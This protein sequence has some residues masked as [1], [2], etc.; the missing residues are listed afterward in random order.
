[1][2]REISETAGREGKR[3]EVLLGESP[4]HSRLWTASGPCPSRGQRQVWRWPGLKQ[5]SHYSLTGAVTDRSTEEAFLE[6]V[7]KW[8]RQDR[9][10]TGQQ[11]AESGATWGRTGTG[12]SLSPV[13]RPEPGF[14]NIGEWNDLPGL[15]QAEGWKSGTCLE[16]TPRDTVLLWLRFQQARFGVGGRG[17][18]LWATWVRISP[19]WEQQESLTAFLQEAGSS[20]WFWKHALA[21][22][23]RKVGRWWAGG[24]EIRWRRRGN[25]EGC[26]VPTLGCVLE[27]EKRTDPRNVDGQMGQARGRCCYQ[28]YFIWRKRAEFK[29]WTQVTWVIKIVLISPSDLVCCETWENGDCL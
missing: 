18:T 5:R 6:E 15:T 12:P 22:E 28:L 25:W 9:E 17:R 14:A 20:T 26:Q 16:D 3:E 8:S 1:M 29:Q 13:L 2:R 27:L 24:M 19:A 21:A 4:S 10:G 23:E 11:S 7:R